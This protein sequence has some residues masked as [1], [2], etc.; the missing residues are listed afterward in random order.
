MERRFRQTLI[1]GLAALAV[2]CGG[3]GSSSQSNTGPSQ[4]SPVA[5]VAI[6]GTLSGTP[7][8]LTFNRQP[9]SV[10]T[11]QVTSQG[12]PASTAKLQPGAVITGTANKSASGYDLQSADLHHELEGTIE[13]VD[14]TGSTLKVMGQTILVN[15][16]TQIED[17]GPGDTYTSLTLADLKVGDRVEV[18][19]SA[20]TEGPIT[21]SRIERES[22]SS[23]MPDSDSVHGLVS[24]LDN[25]AKT[26]E[27]AGYTV[28]YGSASVTGIL[29][30]G[31]RVEVSGT[32]AGMTITATSV[33]VENGYG[34]GPDLTGYLEVCGTLSHLDTTAKTFQI[35]TYTVDYSLAKVE[36]TLAEGAKV[37]VEGMLGTGPMPVLKA[38]QV[39]VEFS[40]TGT[41]SSD[42]EEEGT[43]LALGSAEMTLTVGATTYWTDAATL[44]VKSDAPAV[45]GDLKVGDKVEVHAVKAKTNMAGQTYAAKVEILRP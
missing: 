10:G 4:S 8:A 6:S 26:F 7:G 31:V 3:G 23:P 42:F 25:T 45:F 12:K 19:G 28:S 16:L 17:E 38:Q 13:T 15:A 33:E 35:L 9:L 11:A 32:K 40:S 37:E 44:F 18:Y 2:G 20:S 39:E 36:G 5:S 14:V 30:D 24:K 21:A 29:A 43:V 27:V 34:S 22:P 1:A 41:G